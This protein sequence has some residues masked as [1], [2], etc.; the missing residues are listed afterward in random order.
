[1]WRLTYYCPFIT[2]HLPLLAGDLAHLI[3]GCL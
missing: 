1:M 2:S 3:G